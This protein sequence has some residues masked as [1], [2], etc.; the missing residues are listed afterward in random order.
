MVA[1]YNAVAPHPARESVH[2]QVTFRIDRMSPGDIAPVVALQIA[3]LDGSVVTQLGPVFL[4]RFLRVTLQH[5][6]SRAF[7]A[8]DGSARIVGFAIGSLDV[9][10][11][12]QFVK[13]RVFTALVHALLTP[14]RVALIG[15][16][17]R[18]VVEG[19]PE[20]PIPAELLLLVVDPT[21]RRQGIGAKLLQELENA[22][23]VGNV[24]RYRVAIRSH[25]SEARAFYSALHFEHEQERT[26]LGR[27]MVYLTKRLRAP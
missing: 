12:N 25:L 16:M 22:F 27:P 19:E 13:P 7:V 10:A 11:F 4:T 5:D 1:S 21:T 26:V 24:A 20:P 3:Y 8:R 2:E 17:A 23:A 6:P 14:S 15:S 9:H 18:M